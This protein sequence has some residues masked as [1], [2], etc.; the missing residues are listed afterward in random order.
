MTTFW[1]ELIGTAIM[2]A[3]GLGVCAG[4]NLKK[5][6]SN[7]SGW[8]VFAIGWGFAVAVAA[9]AV[10]QYSG[11]HLNPAITLA[12]ALIGKLPWSEVP[13]YIAGQMIGGMLGATITYF[14]YLPHFKETDDTDAKLG[15]F[16]TGP[17]IPHTFGNFVS[18][19]IGTFILVIG[20]LSIGANKFADGVNPLIVG[21]LIICLCLAMGPTT[22][23]AINPARD[24]GP[25]LVHALLP[26]PGKG[27]SN[28]GYSWIP[29]VAPMFGGA[30]AGVIYKATFLGEPTT[31]LWVVLGVT[32]VILAI[33]NFASKKDQKS[34]PVDRLSA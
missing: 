11:A 5:T 22:G 19:F 30:L 20:V 8:L 31:S 33:V 9:Y 29:I 26:I 14:H 16:A 12:F 2:L 10:V 17:A 4:V 32:I 27:G 1:A 25:R 6:F 34:V 23:L 28:W 7:G 15:V 13:T 18:E 21:F 3:L 24:L